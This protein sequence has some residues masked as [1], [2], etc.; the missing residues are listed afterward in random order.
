MASTNSKVSSPY[1]I[2]ATGNVTIPSGAYMTA[3]GTGSTSYTLNTGAGYNGSWVTAASGPTPS[4]QVTGN[5]EFNGDIKW[6]G[7]DLGK[8]LETIEKR[9]AILTPNPK[10]LEKY[11]ALQKAYAHYKLLEALCHEEDDDK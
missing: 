1:S 9:L 2:G 3:S 5:A 4:I 10:K 6:K 8:L 11:E 7:R